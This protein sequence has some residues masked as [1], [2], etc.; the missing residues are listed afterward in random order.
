M[1]YEHLGFYSI[2][3]GMWSQVVSTAYQQYKWD[4]RLL[5]NGQDNVQLQLG[6]IIVQE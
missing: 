3:Q 4:G 5:I 2:I 6:T 1:G